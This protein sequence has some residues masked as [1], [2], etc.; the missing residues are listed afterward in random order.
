MRET[1]KSKERRAQR[2]GESMDG[3]RAEVRGTH[4]EGCL[5]TKCR[6]ESSESGVSLRKSTRSKENSHN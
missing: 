5:S 3:G 6:R 4:G 1:A 2:E